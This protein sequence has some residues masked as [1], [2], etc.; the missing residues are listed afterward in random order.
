[1]TNLNSKNQQQLETEFKDNDLVCYCFEYT[2]KQIEDDFIK[3]GKSTIMQRIALAKKNGE[4]N[5]A[6]KNPK[7]R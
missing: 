7:G 1:M 2:K 6:I 4:C 5:C 3:N